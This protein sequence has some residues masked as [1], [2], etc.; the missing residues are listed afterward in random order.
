MKGDTLEERLF[1]PEQF[2]VAQAEEIGAH[3]RRKLAM[4]ASPDADVQFKMA[5][6]IGQ[7][8]GV[9]ATAYGR[10][11][12]I[13]HL[14]D[15]ALYIENKVW[16][17]AERAYQTILQAADADVERRPRIVTAA[18][19]YAKPEHTYQVDALALALM[20]VTDQWIPL[21][22]LYELPLVEALQRQGRVFTKP[23]K[24]DAKS[25][26]GFPNVRLLDAGAALVPLHVISPFMDPKDRAL[27]EK[28]IKA[29]GP[30][31]WSWET[32][33]NKSELPARA[34]AVRPGRSTAQDVSKFSR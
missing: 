10:R 4:L 31:G 15:V 5:I 27:K 18:L 16:E 22:S 26:A 8:T 25:A 12:T 33:K 20:L 11:M 21:D 28:A 6:L 1:V 13:K 17:K 24:F 23:L 2:G 7:L 14:P 29:S 32:D 34:G 9:D 3:R 30:S 19:I